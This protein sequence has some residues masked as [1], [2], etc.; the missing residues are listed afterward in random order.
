MVPVF[1]V[2]FYLCSSIAQER[3]GIHSCFIQDVLGHCCENAVFTQISVI[4]RSSLGVL[5]EQAL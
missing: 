4:I 1:C 5:L 3:P 2:H